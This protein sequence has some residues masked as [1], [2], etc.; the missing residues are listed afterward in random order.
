MAPSSYILLEILRMLG[1]GVV[2]DCH[3]LRLCEPSILCFTPHHATHDTI[4]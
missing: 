1:T 4:E 3:K 2:I